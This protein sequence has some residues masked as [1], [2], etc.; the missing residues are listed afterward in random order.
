MISV[1]AQIKGL[2]EGAA[3]FFYL[4]LLGNPVRFTGLSNPSARKQHFISRGFA[5]DFAFTS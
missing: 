1:A 4:R 3:G 2:H 5:H